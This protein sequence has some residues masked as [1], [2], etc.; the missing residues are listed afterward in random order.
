MGESDFTAGGSVRAGN[1]GGL[2]MDAEQLA[3]LEKAAVDVMV[4]E[5]QRGGEPSGVL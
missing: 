4:S 2:R 3:Q 5:E 1:R